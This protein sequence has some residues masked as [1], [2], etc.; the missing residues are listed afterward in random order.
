VRGTLTIVAANHVGN[1]G[2][3]VYRAIVVQKSKK[4]INPFEIKQDKGNAEVSWP[5]IHITS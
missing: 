5:T 3:T 1:L 2:T 4:A